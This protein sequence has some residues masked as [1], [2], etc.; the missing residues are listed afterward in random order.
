M[1]WLRG[2]YFVAREGSVRQAAIVM[3]REKPTISRQIRCLEKELGV[4]LFDRSSGKMM[5]TP[6][7]R[8]LQKQAFELF[9]F[10]KRIKGEFRNEGIDYRGK[11]HI[12]LPHAIIYTILPPYI[13]DFRRQHPGV[14][15]QF[16]GAIRGMIYQKVENA[17]VDFG[18]ALYEKGH[19]TLACY[20]WYESG[21]VMIA[22]KNNPYFPGKVFPTLKQIAEVPLILF[23]HLGLHEPLVEGEFA[24]DWLKPN[25]V[26]IHN[27]FVSVKKYV[28]QGMGASILSEH[29]VSQEDGQIF[30]IYNLDRYFPKRKYVILLKKKKYHSAMVKAFIRTLKPDIDLSA[31]PKLSSSPPLSLTELLQRR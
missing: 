23:A 24:N 6:E 19:K 22:P 25:V 26:M 29:A 14:T 4:I 3:G 5:I 10:V 11:I 13:K 28:A 15:F 16:E 21:L 8:K 7:G 27:N 9:E 31:N 12:A 17:E 2:F 30:D 1:Q 18:I 20:D